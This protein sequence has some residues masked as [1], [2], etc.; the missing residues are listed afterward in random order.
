MLARLAQ[1]YDAPTL[2]TRKLAKRA[3]QMAKPW[4]NQVHASG[5]PRSGMT[6][7]GIK[8]CDSLGKG[9]T[10]ELAALTTT[11]YTCES[12]YMLV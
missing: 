1:V 4:T 7:V 3:Y 9:F 8:L 6:S 5:F 11:A 2:R 12:L 10:I